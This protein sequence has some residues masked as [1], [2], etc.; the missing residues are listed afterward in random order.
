[1]LAV[2]GQTAGI[3]AKRK[4]KKKKTPLF[5]TSPALTGWAVEKTTSMNYA[6]A[7]ELLCSPSKLRSLPILICHSKTSLRA[8]VQCPYDTRTD[9]GTT[10]RASSYHHFAIV[11]RSPFSHLVFDASPPHC[12]PLQARVHDPSTDE[13]TTSRASSCVK[14][15]SRR[16][17]RITS[18]A[19]RSWAHPSAQMCLTRH[20]ERSR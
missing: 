3:H 20:R 5:I 6:E 9:Q 17:T 1:M 18:L 13:G 7:L 15:P 19:A 14:P 16:E 4:K 12:Y 2:F 11:S 10:S 8:R